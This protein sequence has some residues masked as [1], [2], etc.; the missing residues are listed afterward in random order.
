MTSAVTALGV[1][2]ADS[3]NDRYRRALVAFF[4]RRCRDACEAEDMAQ[5]VFVR[6]LGRDRT[7]PVEN[8]DSY[9]F[10]TAANLLKDEARRAAVR[11]VKFHIVYPSADSA[12]AADPLMV[13]SLDPHRILESRQSLSHS[14]D[15]LS[16]LQERTRDIFI[17]SRVEK[18][19][20]RE[21]AEIIG[22]SVSA[23]EK[24]LVKA[25]AHLSKRKR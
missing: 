22:I 1:P 3:L 5:E 6:I 9:I 4:R 24:H 14:L 8:F 25:I 23:V 11:N 10:Q 19:K 15:A 2:T 16:E 20:H 21:I 12:D 18:L 7:S 17:L 13:D